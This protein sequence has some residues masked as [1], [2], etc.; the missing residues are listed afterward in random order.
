MPNFEDLLAA[1]YK[2]D[3]VLSRRLQKNGGLSEREALTQ[4]LLQAAGDK[5]LGELLLQ[6]RQIQLNTAHKLD[7]RR[8]AKAAAFARKKLEKQPDASAWQAWFDGSTHPNPGKM[9]IGGVL[10]SPDGQ[11]I[12]I[13]FAAGHGNS[14]EGEYLALIAVLQEAVRL[15]PEKL[16]VYGDSQIVINDIS[17]TGS[18]GARGLEHYCVQ[19]RQLIAQLKT[20]SLTWVPRH[21]NME[22]DALSQQAAKTGA[23]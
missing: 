16:Q 6:R 4:V 17:L 12:R 13:S 5:S 23:A 22:A 1:A 18:S 15:Q 14:S 2:S 9:G 10:K 11:T 21:K 19:A 8:Q 20:V 3:L 7:M